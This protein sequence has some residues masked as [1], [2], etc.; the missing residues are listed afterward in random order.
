MRTTVAFKGTTPTSG[1]D[2]GNNAKQALGMDSDYYRSSV[3]I[4]KSLKE[5]GADVDL[6]GH[7]LGGGM[8][9]AASGTSGRPATTFNAAGLNPGTAAQY[10]GTSQKSSIEAYR[11]SG[12]ILSGLQ[13]QGWG[14]TLVAAGAGAAIGGPIG[15]LIGAALKAGLS[16]LLPDAAGTLHELPGSGIN[17]VDRHG[18]NQVI[19]GIE[20]Q[21]TEDQTTIAQAT[22]KQCG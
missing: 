6:T 21:K 18:M 2:W 5:S 14:G 13:S 20:S 7:S 19:D 3:G 8:A 17:P 22:G 16:A 15:A 4:G 9:S 1:Q 10:G 12:E 11:V